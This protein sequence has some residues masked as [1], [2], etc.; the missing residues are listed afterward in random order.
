MVWVTTPWAL[1]VTWGTP[2]VYGERSRCG[3]CPCVKT[4]WKSVKPDDLPPLITK[5]KG[6]AARATAGC[7]EQPCAFHVQLHTHV[8]V[9]VTVGTEPG[10]L[11]TCPVLR[12][13]HIHGSCSLQECSCS[14]AWL[15][16]MAMRRDIS[17]CLLVVSRVGSRV[18]LDQSEGGGIAPGA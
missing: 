3:T 11:A 9:W 18:T 4:C 8:V 2:S 7:K 10:R 14:C 6:V 12:D 5:R 17:W 16:F 1:T 15:T 13:I